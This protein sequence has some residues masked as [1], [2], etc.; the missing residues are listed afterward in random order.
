M[1]PAGR[2][3]TSPTPT[4]P[5]WLTICFFATGATGLIYETTWARLLELYLGSTQY[6]ISTVL[7]VFMFGLAAG[8][9]LG[10][11]LA[12]RVPSPLR[13]Y[14]A[15][16]IMAGLYCLA[17]P[18]LFRWMGEAALGG[19]AL[20]DLEEAW[21]RGEHFALAALVLLPPTLLMG[22]TLPL[23]VRG[24]VQSLGGVGAG[25]S[26]LYALNTLG[27]VGGC[28]LAGFAA[29]RWLGIAHT[30]VATGLT[31]VAIG[32]LVVWLARADPSAGEPAP[33]SARTARRPSA[34]PVP[35]QVGLLLAVA[36]GS[37]FAALAYEVLWFRV[38]ALVLGSSI[39]AFTV[40]LC[41]FLAGISLG[42]ELLAP[43]LLRRVDPV[44]AL[45]MVQ[46]TVAFAVLAGVPLYS[47]LPDAFLTLFQGLSEQFWLFT[48]V[49]S[50]ICFSLMLVPTLCLGAVLPI[51]AHL[52]VRRAEAIGTEVG[53]VYF[54]NTL[55]AIAGS[56]CA[57]FVLQPLIG[58][59]SSILVVASLSGALGVTLLIVLAVREPPKRGRRR[60]QKE[61]T[62]LAWTAAALPV[63]FGVCLWLLPSWDGQ[64]MTVGPYVNQ[65]EV[66]RFL[67]S[68][69]RGEAI[70]DLLYYREGVHAVIS[71]RRARDGSWLSYQANGKW[72]GS[73]GETAPNWSLLGHIPMLL[74]DDPQ[75]A[76]L[77]GLGTGIT[78]GALLDYPVERI[79][80]AEIE[81]AVVEAA[82]YFAEAH[83]DALRDPRVRIYRSDGRTFLGVDD[84][85]YDVIV[86][87]VSDPWISGVSNLFTRE[88]FGRVHDRLSDRG[89]AA[90]WFQNYRISTRDLK[91]ALH[92]LATVFPDV[93]VWAPHD[94]PADLIL[95]AGKRPI[96]IDAERLYDRLD[97]HSDPA[98]LK[99]AGIETIFHF[100][101]LRL[102][103][104]A[105]LRRFAS[106]VPMHTDDLP[107]LEFSLPRQLYT[108]VHAGIEERAWALM[109][110]AREL[111]PPVDVPAPLRARFYYGLAS[112]YSYYSY[113]EPH[114]IALFRRVLDLEPDNAAARS[115]LQKK[116][117]LE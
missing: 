88:Y 42:S 68:Y 24:V 41:T 52:R 75:R 55:G 96:R 4:A 113:R 37:G 98:A 94:D 70:D 16:E 99:A 7:S 35:T 5:L 12:D 34:A 57:G 14:G 28:A 19:L 63:A 59:Q 11:R 3:G 33:V 26:R 103:G 78:L 102:I 40:M 89:I 81:P 8:S 31:D 21:F 77:V 32:A 83:G 65:G 90:I 45:A 51:V 79:D 116:G 107:H 29:L 109:Q 66:T 91:I 80:V 9:A 25:V 117:A 112:V 47:R 85:S 76:L 74:Q 62:R 106:G 108:D 38:L 60:A 10:G 100:L 6:A 73:I 110:G 30:L 111:E 22:T 18:A 114:A 72:E 104:D 23:V 2:D 27:A 86:S 49:Q 20:Q 61:S 105:D 87:G 84:G 97:G 1:G 69:E 17:T 95:I 64:R 115:Y 39:Y 36:A 82:D 15:I 44:R 50:T 101:N 46:I 67:E 53:D 93:S 13:T 54:V 48:L 56:L 58:I 43:R 71:V 92:T